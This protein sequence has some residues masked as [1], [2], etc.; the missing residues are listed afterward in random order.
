MSLLL[1]SCTIQ[2]LR[3]MVM[4]NFIS[5]L[6][7]TMR[8]PRI[9]LM[10]YLNFWV[11]LWKCFQI[12]IWTSRLSKTDCPLQCEEASF[13]LLRGSIEQKDGG[14]WNSLS[15][16][17]YGARTSV[18]CLWIK[19]HNIC[20]PGSQASG[21]G[22]KLTSSVFLILKQLCTWCKRLTATK[23]CPTLSNL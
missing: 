9:C 11:C 22:L 10:R 2:P 12:S 7:W 3:I 4:V 16:S 1:Q 20:T 18:F 8:Y 6:E 17:D 15:L 5:Q 21:V 13:N 14:R 23:P 19:I